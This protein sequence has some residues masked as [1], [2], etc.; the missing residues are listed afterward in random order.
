MRYYKCSNC[1][2]PV[3]EGSKFCPECGSRIVDTRIFNET[4]TKKKKKRFPIGLLIFLVILTAAAVWGKREYDVYNYGINLHNAVYYS[5][6]SAEH[7]DNVG[8]LFI[9]VWNNS[10]YQIQDEETDKFTRTNNGAGQFYSDFDDALDLVILDKD[11]QAELSQAKED[12]NSAVD[13]MGKLTNPPKRY[14]EAYRD[15][16]AFYTDFMSF[17]NVVGNPNGS[18]EDYSDKYVEARDKL[19]QSYYSVSMY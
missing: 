17:Y 1:E 15:M 18:L 6:E 7:L 19:L 11:Y 5:M 12:K 13:C 3:K 10:I 4:P 16:K 14:E 2:C 8:I 9:N